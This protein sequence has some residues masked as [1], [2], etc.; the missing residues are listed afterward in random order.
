MIYRTRLPTSAKSKKNNDVSID[1][2][3]LKR[4]PNC[5]KRKML[6]KHNYRRTDENINDGKLYKYSHC[7]NC[8]YTNYI[9]IN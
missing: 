3:F 8:D 1:G 7:K 2:D 6:I 4:C 9:P 5:S